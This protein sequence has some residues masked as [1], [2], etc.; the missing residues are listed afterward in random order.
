MRLQTSIGLSALGAAHFYFL[1]TGKE[2]EVHVDARHAILEF[3][4]PIPLQT[5]DTHRN[6]RC[7]FRYPQ[8]VK[9][10]TR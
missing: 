5:P 4:K 1:R 6:I 3:S 2:E 8:T 9:G 10:T 7:A